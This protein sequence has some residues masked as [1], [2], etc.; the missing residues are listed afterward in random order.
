M[1]DKFRKPAGALAV[2]LVCAA[3]LS[4]TG[5][6]S[7]TTKLS[8]GDIS[9][10]VVSNGGFVVEKGNYV[11]FINGAE[12]Y[13][14]SNKYGEV[15][16]GAL[17]RIAKSDLNAKN[18]DK[19]ETVVPMLF[20]AQNYDAGIYI[21]G[22]YVYYASPTT[23]KDL[24]GVVHNESLS[25]RRSKLDGTDSM[26]KSY[27]FR[28]DD[29]TVEYRYVE[30]DGVVYCLHVD[31]TELYSY[32]TSTRKD[33]VLVK[34]ASEYFFDESDPTNPTVYYTMSV[35]E[36]ADTGYS[37]SAEYNQLYTVDADATATVDS[38]AASYTLSTGK[39][40]DFDGA[41]L[42][43]N[44]D[45]FDASDYT[46]Y[47]YVNLG[48]LVLDGIGS[49]SSYTDKR[50]SDDDNA[51][52][53]SVNGYIY[54]VLTYRNGG[55]YFTRT[56]VNQ[57]SSDADDT[58]LY[59]LPETALAAA[60]WNSVTGNKSAEL[61]VVA[62]NTTNAS[63]SA[64]F[65][66]SEEGGERIHS[67]LYFDSA[68]SVIYKATADE[69][70]NATAIRMVTQAS[71]VTLWTTRG[72]YLYYYASG[73]NGNNLSR[74]NYT[75]GK[76]DYGAFAESEEYKPMQI[77][78]VDWNS[79]WY[80]PEFVGSDLFFSNAQSFG[81]TT[82]NYI[83]VVSLAGS[84]AD[85]IMT[86]DELKAF[87]EEYEEITDYIAEFG[88]NENADL[89]T[90]LTYVFRTGASAEDNLFE[91]VL[92]AAKEAGYKDHYLYSEYAI[93]EFR[94]FTART[95]SANQEAT[96]YATKFCNEDG[97]Y[98]DRES[99]FFNR[100]G[101]MK[102]SDEEAIGEAWRTS[103]KTL[104]EAEE[105]EGLT[106]KQKIWIGVGVGAGVIV[107]AAAVATVVIVCKKKAKEKADREA[108]AIRKKPVI[109]T[110]DDKSIDVYA[111][112]EEPVEEKTEEKEVPEEISDGTETEAIP[113]ESD[114]EKPE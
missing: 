15:V 50:F 83:Y 32:N 3:A 37:S 91:T 10:E 85:G 86:A 70:G 46:T 63:S 34:G 99:Y 17:M 65:S 102:E 114:E 7:Y 77:L 112:D 103:L 56:D 14:A 71:G 31:G 16:K 94:A 72:E 5:C 42:K 47:P 88:E 76:D 40:Y 60:D 81:S 20:V 52:A 55:I 90:A 23:E 79:G 24:D 98:Y 4:L 104:P 12:D 18:Y 75:G 89:Q 101:A 45:G 59:Y 109:D 6:G 33:T 36:H 96:D 62:Q 74:V 29:N 95:T 82:Y 61:D 35:T 100:I 21:Y 19:A 87:N 92:A 39:T 49:N 113:E 57:T 48:K 107:I 111:S 26:A 110:T 44:L 43:D 8:A 67:Y 84:G 1:R 80:K 2:A 78:D 27:F 97:V 73:A 13:T 38:S 51:E 68:E 66:V 9:G 30:K 11:Y 93:N 69:R 41:Y 58:L 106:T 28:S 108:T 105:S 54:S 53:F 22:D 25:F 64:L